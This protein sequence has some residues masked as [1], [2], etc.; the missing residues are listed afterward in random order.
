MDGLLLLPHFGNENPNAGAFY[1]TEYTKYWTSIRTKLIKPN[2]T[3]KPNN[4]QKEYEQKNLGIFIDTLLL[5]FC[6]Q[7]YIVFFAAAWL[8][9]S[10]KL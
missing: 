3:N 7:F 6:V 8:V 4:K 9:S 5:L 10:Y 1:N 2:I